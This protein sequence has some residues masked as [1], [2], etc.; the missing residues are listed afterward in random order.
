MVP[1][2]NYSTFYIFAN[3]L[4]CKYFMRVK[5]TANTDITNILCTD[6]SNNS[7]LVDTEFDIEAKW[8]QLKITGDRRQIQDICINNESIKMVLN[9]GTQYQN[10]FS[11]WIHGD[12]NKLFERV[13]GCIDQPD[14]LRWQ[15]ISKKYLA[16][17]SYNDVA[18]DF[19]PEHVKKFF[20]DGQGPYWWNYD[21]K[22]SL[23]FKNVELQIDKEKLMESLNDD[24]TY[25][26]QKFYDSVY[27]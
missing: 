24:L 17:V 6:L 3:L 18:P 16:T 20:A 10:V 4:S 5:I 25:S 12:L 11:I 22:D 14:L 27:I 19:V 15:D 7:V 21:N 23:P 2:C 8:Y 1:C 26:D 13:F 9:S